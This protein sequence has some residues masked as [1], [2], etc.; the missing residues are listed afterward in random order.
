MRSKICPSDIGDRSARQQ[1]E[2]AALSTT[3]LMARA[4]ADLACSQGF[5]ARVTGDIAKAQADGNSTLVVRLNGISQ[6]ILELDS[7]ATQ[8]AMGIAHLVSRQARLIE[9]LDKVQEHCGALDDIY[10]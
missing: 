7:Q 4:E 9:A 10:E 5:V 6:R 1:G 2:V 8:L 3:D